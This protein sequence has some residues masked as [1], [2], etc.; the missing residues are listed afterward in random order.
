MGRNSVLGLSLLAIL[1]LSV[2][3]AFAGPIQL[4]TF[5]GLQDMQQVGNFYN[6]GGP[7]NVPNLGISFSSNFYGLRSECATGSTIGNCIPGGQG[8]GAFLPDPTQTPAIFILG[9]PGTMATGYMNVTG[10]FSSGINFLYTAAF[11][12]TFTVWSGANGTG[13]V[14]ATLTLNPNNGACAGGP[15]YC[16]WTSVGVAFSGTAGSVTFSG[17]AN[18]IGITDVTLGSNLSALPEPSSFW[19]LGSGLLGVAVP[20]VR[21]LLKI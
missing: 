2:S 3:P 4:I 12:E 1:F 18:G 21:R 19:L 13:T 15:A 5:N 14:L 8:S 10:G 17:S 7:S 11:K 9:T 16:N 20:R 6:G